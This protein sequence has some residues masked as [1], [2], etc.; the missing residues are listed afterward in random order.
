MLNVKTIKAA[1]IG[2]DLLQ[3]ERQIQMQNLMREK[4]MAMQIAQARELF[5]WWAS[6]Y[7]IAGTA[8]IAG[9]GQVFCSN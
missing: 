3:L 1:L 2:N 8:M 9:S 6:F 7:A 5:N 4:Q